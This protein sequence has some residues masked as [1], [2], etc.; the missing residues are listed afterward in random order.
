MTQPFSRITLKVY[1]PVSV[2]F[3]LATLV[4]DIKVF[5][6]SL[7]SIESIAEVAE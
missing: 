5:E 7:H 3:T 1:V 4:E 6:G 2:V